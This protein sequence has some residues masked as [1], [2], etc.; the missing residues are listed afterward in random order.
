MDNIIQDFTK[1]LLP[2]SDDPEDNFDTIMTKINN[3]SEDIGKKIDGLQ[4]GSTKFADEIKAQQQLLTSSIGILTEINNEEMGKMK[5]SK[6]ELI[7]KLNKLYVNLNDK[8]TQLNKINLPSDDNSTLP[9]L[10][11]LHQTL[12]KLKSDLNGLQNQGKTPPP[13]SP[14]ASPQSGQNSLIGGKKTR[15]KRKRG[16]KTVKK[17]RKKYK[18]GYTYKKFRR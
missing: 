5:R 8:L 10:N 18:G 1:T 13:T 15:N 12:G 6:S 9:L 14:P 16:K 3:T 17:H 11:T 2:N 7:E 4:K